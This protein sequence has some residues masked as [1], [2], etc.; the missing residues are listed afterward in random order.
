MA[1]V[2][3]CWEDPTGVLVNGVNTKCKTTHKCEVD[4]Q[5]QPGISYAEAIEHCAQNN[6][7]R[8]CTREEIEQSEVCCGTGG[9]CNW[10]AVWTSTPETGL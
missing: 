10:H 5:Q 7:R 4:G 9:N 3:C 2:R 6:C 1:G 8:I